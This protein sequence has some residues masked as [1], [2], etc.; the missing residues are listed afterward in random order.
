MLKNF[1]YAFLAIGIFATI[2]DTSALIPLVIGAVLL[3]L[4]FVRNVA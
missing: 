2:S 3:A 1:G 4:H